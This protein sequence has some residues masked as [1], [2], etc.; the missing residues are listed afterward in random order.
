V[1]KA[2]FFVTIGGMAQMQPLE[3]Q[4]STA[5]K[6]ISGCWYIVEILC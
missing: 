1:S 3:T 4:A 6:K 2:Y 5:S